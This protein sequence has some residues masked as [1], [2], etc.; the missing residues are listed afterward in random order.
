MSATLSILGLYNYDNSLFDNLVLP[1][2][3]D[4]DD[5]TDN[6][7]LE[8]AELEVIYPSID[9]MKFAIGSWSRKELPV[10]DKL[11]A[12]TMLEY[13]PIHNYDRTEEVTDSETKSNKTDTSGTTNI[14]GNDSEVRNLFGTDNQTR[15]LTET[16]KE[17]VNKVETNKETRNLNTTDDEL[18]DLTQNTIHDS[19]TSGSTTNSGKDT[20]KES[21]YGF[22]QTTTATATPSKLFEN[23]L[24][25][26]NESTG[27]INYET[28]MTDTGTVGK[29]IAE[30]GTVNNDKTDTGTVD[31]LLTDS[32]TVNRNMSDSGSITHSKSDNV[33]LNNE[34]VD[35]GTVERTHNMRAFGNIGVTTTQQ[36]LEA[37]R[38]VVK[39][40]IIDYI[41]DS[42]KGRFC[43]LIY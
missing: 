9:M 7:L 22:N 37:E 35:N 41:V 32:G 20:N 43:L 5:V 30:T 18:R 13:N 34:V 31:N 15:N 19:D 39:F 27:K 42:F 12:T 36:M 25:S 24:G 16:N 3:I 23:E 1:L 38:N 21:V 40:N 2:G 10:W 11:Y 14:N 33:V 28:N 4:K 17:T 26:K 6:L 29:T 8:L